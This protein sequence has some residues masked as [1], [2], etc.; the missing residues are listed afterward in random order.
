MLLCLLIVEAVI[1][2][3]LHRNTYTQRTY[4]QCACI[5]DEI[6]IIFIQRSISWFCMKCKMLPLAEAERRV[7]GVSLKFL[8]TF[9]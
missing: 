7:H 1:V 9:L 5:T 4:T 6:L 2:I 8:Y 3:K